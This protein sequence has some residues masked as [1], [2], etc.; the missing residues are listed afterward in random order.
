[1]LARASVSPSV[2]TGAVW[3]VGAGIILAYC[4]YPS[5][6]LGL[7]G[8][9]AIA[10]LVAA[11]TWRPL[12]AALA[13]AAGVTLVFLALGYS[14]FESY[15]VL[16]QPYYDGLGGKRSYVYWVWATSRPY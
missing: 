5:Y 2:T 12:V 6:G 11:R 8:L 3:A 1:M 16:R 14:W 13:G 9:L 15:P 10:V 4:V 7:L